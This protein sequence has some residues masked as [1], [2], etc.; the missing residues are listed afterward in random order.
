MAASFASGSTIPLTPEHFADEINANDDSVFALLCPLTENARDAFDATVNTVIKNT[1]DYDHFRQFLRVGEKRAV[2]AVSVYSEDEGEKAPGAAQWTGEFKFSMDAS[3]NDPQC[4]WLGSKCPPGETDILLAP[5]AGHQSLGIAHKH[6]R[7]FLHPHSYRFVLEARHSVNIGGKILTRARQQILEDGDTIIIGGCCTYSF[8]YT[9][10]YEGPLFADMLSQHF[11]CGTLDP[12]LTPS[13]IGTP[14]S[15]RNH[16]CSPSAF[17]QG[18]F[19]TV[20]VGWTREGS[21]VAIKRFKNPKKQEILSHKMMM[22]HIRGHENIL[23]L[24][25]CVENFETAVPDAYC[26]YTPLA[27]VTLRDIIPTHQTGIKTKIALLSDYL[28][29]LSYLHEQKNVMHLDISPGNLAV[30]SLNNPKG[31]IID[32]DAMVD[33]IPCKDHSKGTMIYLAPEI[34]DLKNKKTDKPFERSVDVWAL[35]LCMFD[36]CQGEFLLWKRL[37]PRESSPQ[38]SNAVSEDRYLKFQKKMQEMKSSAATP[39]HTEFF[40]WVEEMVQYY[41]RQRSTASQ[42]H[43]TVFDVSKFL[44]RDSIVP[45]RAAKRARED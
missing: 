27:T 15:L 31:I 44:G 7:M 17:A 37:H 33:S 41:A 35:G 20:S 4:W 5:G 14:I 29:G 36:L 45:L 11:G 32:L 10:F 42:L 6:A 25:E 3:T 38:L 1:P 8:H 2:R 24:L 43:S 21:T 30:M 23:Q 22:E 12:H 34:M 16:F 19:G 39:S 26:V 13:S 9:A 40:T 18:T 28:C